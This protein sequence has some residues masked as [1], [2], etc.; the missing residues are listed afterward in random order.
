MNNYKRTQLLTQKVF[1][2]TSETQVQ[3][4]ELDI[5]VNER[6]P[7][8][9]ETKDIFLVNDIE[10]QNNSVER[11]MKNFQEWKSGLTDKN[12]AHFGISFLYEY[13]F[14]LTIQKSAVILSFR[15]NL[16]CF[17]FSVLRFL[18]NDRQTVKN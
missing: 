12:S 7:Y 6:L 3:F 13:P 5:P 9:L 1:D 17:I 4:Q 8:E 2:D 18:K 15:R 16:N 14:L 11:Q 10:Y